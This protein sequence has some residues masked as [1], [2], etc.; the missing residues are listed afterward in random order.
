MKKTIIII[1]TILIL[2]FVTHL[3]G[4]CADKF[5]YI[6]GFNV[7]TWGGGAEVASKYKEIEGLEKVSDLTT[8]FDRDLVAR[9]NATSGPYINDSG[10]YW[11]IAVNSGNGNYAYF[12]N[13][14]NSVASSVAIFTGNKILYFK[15]QI[16]W[17]DT[18]MTNGVWHL[19]IN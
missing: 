14:Q 10:Y 6:V 2:T 19:S 12:G 5:A 17:F 18:T 7:P 9:I 1:S 8:Y 16:P 15:T 11:A 4:V 3:C 13:D